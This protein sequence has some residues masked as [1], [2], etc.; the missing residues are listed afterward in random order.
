MRGGKGKAGREQCFGER[1]ERVKSSGE[2]QSNKESSKKES[3][4]EQ[5]E[6]GGTFKCSKIPTA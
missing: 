5:V 6:E 3:P 4:T 2:E 1:E